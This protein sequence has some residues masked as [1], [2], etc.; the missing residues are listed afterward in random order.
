MTCQGPKDI[1]IEKMTSQNR[2][3]RDKRGW[4]MAEWLELGKWLYEAK[5]PLAGHLSLNPKFLVLNSFF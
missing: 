3:G 2:P 4:S 5:K 1:V